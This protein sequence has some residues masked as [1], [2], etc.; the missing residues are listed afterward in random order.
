MAQEEASGNP[1]FSHFGAEANLFDKIGELFE[2]YGNTGSG[3]KRYYVHNDEEA[4]DLNKRLGCNVTSG[5]FTP[6]EDL[7]AGTDILFYEGLHG[8]VKA[9]APSCGSRDRG[10]CRLSIWSG[11]RR[12]SAITMTVAI[13]KMSSLIPSYA[14]CMTM[15]TTLHR[16]SGARISTSSACQWWDTS[17]PFIARDIPTADESMVCHSVRQSN[18]IQC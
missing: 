12:F 14:A 1:H 2:T 17:N 9:A 13:A 18:Q 10:L 4:V 15:F 6:W 3:Q 5:D 7:E 16:N 8:L 11:S